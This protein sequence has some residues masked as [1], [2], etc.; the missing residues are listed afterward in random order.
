MSKPD[1][2][3]YVPRAYPR[4]RVREVAVIIVVD[5]NIRHECPRIVRAN[6][7]AAEFAERIRVELIRIQGDS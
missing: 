3:G 2:S 4:E 1:P 7:T 6:E 5:T